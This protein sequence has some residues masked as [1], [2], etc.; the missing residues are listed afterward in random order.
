M[1]STAPQSAVQGPVEKVTAAIPW[2]KSQ[3][4]IALLQI[5]IVLLLGWVLQGLTTRAWDL[6]S[7]GA[8]VVSNVLVLL[9]DW[10]SPNIVAPL[11]AFNRRNVN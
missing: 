6:Y 3:R 10:W 11:A 8:L 2:Y 5:T 1:S 9:K 7:L 4:A